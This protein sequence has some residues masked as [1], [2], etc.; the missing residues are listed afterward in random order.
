VLSENILAPAIRVAKNIVKT[1]AEPTVLHN[2]RRVCLLF[3]NLAIVARVSVADERAFATE[4]CELAVS[5]HLFERGA[6]VVPPSEIMPAAPVIGNGMVVTLWPHIVH[7]QAEYDDLAAVAQCARAL[8]RVHEAFADYPGKLP[9]YW[10]RIEECAS[11]LRDPKALPTLKSD[12]RA[13]LIR[14]FERARASMGDCEIIPRP[15]HG[16]AH[17][18]NAFMTRNGPLWMDFEA[19]SR[20]P[21]EWDAAAAPYLPA[22]G[23]LDKNL[24]AV[25]SQLRSVCVAV[26]CSAL[27]DDPEKRAA[28]A[29]QIAKLRAEAA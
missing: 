24:F 16:D 19:A 9:S 29:H 26:W 5:R 27:A 12:D 20:G 21:Y 23:S 7:A 10:D 11:L 3:S 8:K 15:I 18:G 13:F 28:A 4:T 22:Y 14:T 2:S 1:A 25:M 6:P 17:I